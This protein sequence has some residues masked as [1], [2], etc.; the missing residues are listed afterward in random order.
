M[1]QMVEALRVS[2][3]VDLGPF[4]RFLW[5]RELPHRVAFEGDQVLY[6]PEGVDPEL[7]K[8]LYQQWQA[9]IELDSL[10]K[11]SRV[12]GPRLDPRRFPLTLSL[13]LLSALCSVLI[14]FGDDLGWLA[15]LTITPFFIDAGQLAYP[16]LDYNL[17][18]L[19]FWRL[20]TPLF[21][22][23]SAMHLVFNGL[24]LWLVGQ[25]IEQ[26]QGSMALL[27]LVLA[28]GVVS[29]LAQYWASG[30]VFGGLSGVVFALLAYTWLWDKLTASRY[31]GLPPALMI[32]MVVWV[33]LGYSG[34]L[35]AIG[36]GG[37]ANTAH[38]V[39]LLSGLAL[40]VIG[41]RLAKVNSEQR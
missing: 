30:P 7:V 10:P 35:T 22:H 27:L 17:Q 23:F 39:G 31:F 40:A 41:C 14:G 6:V 1:Q 37:I 38:F 29:N 21:M 33:L 25:R 4:T 13:L 24:W 36:F 12:P 32:L 34:M 19:E 26:R 16:G 2:D 20:V 18:S 9:G 3:E 11:I 28:S 15:K 8:Y 5:Q